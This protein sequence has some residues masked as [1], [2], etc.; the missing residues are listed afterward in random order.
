M[1]GEPPTATLTVMLDRKQ[2]LGLGLL[3]A[4]TLV[5]GGCSSGSSG[6]AGSSVGPTGSTQGDTGG[7]SSDGGFVPPTGTSSTGLLFEEYTNAQF[8]YKL[9]YPGGWRVKEEGDTTRIAKLGN[10]IVVTV[11]TADAAP[12]AKGVRESLAKQIDNGAV[13]EVV[14]APKDVKLAGAPAVRLVFTQERP[15]S[16]TAPAETIVVLRYML[17]HSG[18]VAVFSLQ[19]PQ[20]VDNMDAFEFIARRFSWT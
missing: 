10:A 7:G 20:D 15:A 4:V 18:K 1:S 3:A 2:A 8:G 11:R 17:F 16:D 14:D 13:A 12:K 19:S 6:T 9:A 5:L